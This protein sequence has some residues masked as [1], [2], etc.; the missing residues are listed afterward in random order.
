MAVTEAEQFENKTGTVTVI[1]CAEGGWCLDSL[2]NGSYV[3][4]K[5]MDFTTAARQFNARVS[6]TGQTNQIEIYLDNISGQPAGVL[7]VTPTAGKTVYSI[8]SCVL[9][10]VTGIRDVY[11]V[12]KRSSGSS[13]TLNSFSFQE[14]IGPVALHR[15]ETAG[16]DEGLGLT[17][18]PNPA[19][20]TVNITCS[21]L[22]PSDMCLD[23]YSIKGQLVKTINRKKQE[24]G[25]Y[26]FTFKLDPKYCLPG[27]YLVRLQ[28]GDHRRTDV[29]EIKCN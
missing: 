9:N 1:P 22:E 19:K 18:C 21:L 25:D 12:F 14:Q 5:N 10:E 29:M 4:F 17:I 2:S 24:A 3:V 6:A 11:L 23:I 20:S 28:A 8:Q 7:S 13:M 16:E 27:Y 26:N 15:W